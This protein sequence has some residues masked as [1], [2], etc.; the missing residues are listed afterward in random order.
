MVVPHK[1]ATEITALSWSWGGYFFLIWTTTIVSVMTETINSPNWIKS[2]NSS[3]Y[4]TYIPFTPFVFQLRG[5]KCYPRIRRNRPPTVLVCLLCLWYQSFIRP[6]T[7]QVHSF[8]P[9]ADGLT[10]PP[11]RDILEIQKGRHTEQ[12]VC[13]LQSNRF[14]SDRLIGKSGGH[15]FFIW[16][17]RAMSAIIN[18]PNWKRSE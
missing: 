14:R 5:K 18:V 2:W 15:F 3:E 11:P 12:A 16:S 13:P 9:A 10:F 6:S 4:V 7:P 17:I 8:L 1:M